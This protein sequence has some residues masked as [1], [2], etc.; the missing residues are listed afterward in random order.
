MAN[1]N[2]KMT[3]TADSKQ[4]QNSLGSLV[5]SIAKTSLSI[6]SITMAAKQLYSTCKELI[7]LGTQ[8]A[9]AQE[10]L[11]AVLSAA[12]TTA[13]I[14]SSRILEL[15][16]SISDLT[17]IEEQSVYAAEK[18]LVSF[19]SLN[20]E[21]FERTL[22]LSADV[23]MALGTDI[24]DAAKKLGQVLASPTQGLDGL[25]EIGIAFTAQEQKQIK[26]VYEANGAYEA[27]VLILDKVEKAYGKSAIAI[28]NSTANLTTKISETMK[29]SMANLGQEMLNMIEP[30]LEKIEKRW[31]KFSSESNLS[32]KIS[33]VA[34]QT[35]NLLE[36]EIDSIDFSK[37]TDAELEEVLDYFAQKAEDYAGIYKFLY[38]T[39]V[40]LENLTSRSE[41]RAEIERRKNNPTTSESTSVS[42][43]SVPEDF[44]SSYGS[45]S[46]AYQI[47]Q[48]QAV[49][50]E[51]NFYISKLSAATSESDNATVAY[52]NEIVSSMQS[53]IDALQSVAETTTKSQEIFATYGLKSKT[54]Q[55]EQLQ[56]QIDEVTAL[57]DSMTIVAENG[58]KYYNLDYGISDM[59][60]S[61]LEDFKVA[62]KEV[63][64]IIKS[65]QE[66][67]A[68]LDEVV[69]DTTIEDLLNSYGSLSKTFSED[70]S[71]ETIKEIKA[72]LDSLA[73][74]DSAKV[75]LQ[76][77]YDSLTAVAEDTTIEDI[78]SSLG[79]YSESYQADQL[80][81]QI[82][83]VKAALDSLADTDP[84]KKYLQ[85]IYDGMTKVE[86][87]SSSLKDT[88]KD[89]G[90]AMLDTFSTI[91]SAIAD[92]WSNEADALKESMEEQ[93]EAGELTIAQKEEMQNEID[94]LNR[95]AFETNK[96]N[97]LA[98]ATISLASTII[99]IWEQYK[100]NI[101]AIAALSAL[102]TA[103]WGAQV[104][105]ISSQKY[106]P[107]ATGG[108]VTGPTHALIGEA[109]PEA[110]IPLKDKRAQSYLG[111]ANP[112]QINITIE[113][114]ADEE[115]VFN[116]IERAQR[117][118]LL[119][120]WRYA[121]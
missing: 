47:A 87:K 110:I 8:E 112:V 93:E 119:P 100:G 22:Q 38:G 117:T 60:I 23:A 115:V 34:R 71:A 95:K 25:K 69:A 30:I 46:K 120:S 21:G 97:S 43:F 104:A 11:N 64:E 68:S 33:S 77:I 111:T 102:A 55:K 59:G 41:L 48:Y 103:S 51:A 81:E 7:E 109:G 1:T 31:L 82:N 29:D 3:V 94:E 91:A 116:A 4:A 79:S 36:G 35:K 98:Q 73:D 80:A 26:K 113:G 19:D 84:A 74:G 107:M 12:G 56:A 40:S 70:Q 121:N 90:S 72:A 17:G 106:T 27:Q 66:D 37:F 52:L 39:T 24:S 75:Y 9:L 85:E 118:G 78:L 10:R 67:L 20:K 16:S 58:K 42:G 13:K 83:N 45:S 50:D 49:I 6:A 63:C 2:L 99:G 105:V 28:G 114:N 57:R 88:L 89:I 44:L 5:S 54:Y 96:A 92:I 101:G 62:Y 53:K 108:I 18:V 15:A 32:L 61:N 65:L 14:S 76:E 86:E